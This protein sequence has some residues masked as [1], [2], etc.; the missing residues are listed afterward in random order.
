M[1]SFPDTEAFV[2]SRY[3]INADTPPLSSSLQVSWVVEVTM[4]YIAVYIRVILSSLWKLFIRV[5][6][7]FLFFNTAGNKLNAQQTKPRATD[8]HI[9][10]QSKG[11]DRASK[12]QQKRPLPQELCQWTT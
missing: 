3:N 1:H 8:S 2:T 10:A 5:I 4:L 9:D 12:I 7:S 11:E 6:T